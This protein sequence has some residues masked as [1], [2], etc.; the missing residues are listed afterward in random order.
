MSQAESFLFYLLFLLVSAKIMGEITE[1]L[2]FPSTIGYL[3]TGMIYASPLLNSRF[4][5]FLGPLTAD[6][7]IAVFGQ[8]GAILLLFVAG[9]RELDTLKLVENK[10]AA[11]SSSLLGFFF[12]FFAV[13]FLA[14]NSQVIDPLLSFSFPQTLI[15]VTALSVSSVVPVVKVLIQNEK[16]NSRPGKLILSSA[17]LNAIIGLVVFTLFSISLSSGRTGME[18]LLVAV[19]FV[20]LFYVGENIIPLLLEFSGRFS[21]EEAQFTVAFVI[22]LLLAG[23]AKF[24]GLHGVIGA[25]VA[26]IIVSKSSLKH[27]GEFSEKLSSLAYGV[28]V[29]LFFVW[30]GLNFKLPFFSWFFFALL[31][32]V[33]VT[34]FLGVYLGLRANGVRGGDAIGVGLGMLPRGGVDLVILSAL[35]V[36]VPPSFVEGVMG[37]VIYSSVIIT[38]LF[39]TVISALLLKLSIKQKVF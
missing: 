27:G 12:P 32:T 10:T 1:R 19:V 26:G 15:L 16:L 21:V 20:V 6:P 31:I 5:W 18:S 38:A 29:P 9:M 24:F 39:A 13:L 34:N 23:M 35:F 36:V 2:G 8:M 17:V 3:L 22:M 4:E 33:L 30:V 14:L 28:F 37:Q 7:S 11:V 25:F